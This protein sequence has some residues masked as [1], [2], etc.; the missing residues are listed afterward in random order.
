MTFFLAPSQGKGQRAV[1]KLQGSS[2]PDIQ[3]WLYS[4]VCF[5]LLGIWIQIVGFSIAPGFIRW[6]GELWEISVI[7]PRTREGTFLWNLRPEAGVKFRGTENI[8]L[9]LL[10][11]MGSLQLIVCFHR[12]QSPSISMVSSYQNTELYSIPVPK[13]TSRSEQ[14]CL[15]HSTFILALSKHLL[16]LPQGLNFSQVFPFLYTVPQPYSTMQEFSYIL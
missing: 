11:E 6:S 16:V 12:N 15:N 1:G 5:G 2:V 14:S 8:M 7:E 3:P 13:F 4:M 10:I 9:R